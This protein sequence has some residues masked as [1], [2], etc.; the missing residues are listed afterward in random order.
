IFFTLIYVSIFLKEHV[1]RFQSVGIEIA[2]VGMFFIIKPA[3]DL[4]VVPYILGFLSAV[5]AAGAYTVLR[6]LGDKEQ[7]YTVV[8]YF[9]FFT[10]VILLPYVVLFYEPMSVKLW[11]Y[12]LL[13][14]LFVRVGQFGI[15]VAYKYAPA[16]RVSIF[17]YSTV[18]YSALRS[19][20]CFDQI[21]DVCSCVSYINVFGA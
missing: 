20:L 8:F 13:A 14:G 3:F 18:V 9:S 15:T 19:I 10:T 1:R 21:L 5:F 11:V 6:V 2:F 7:F 12:L 17:F 4:E 16:K